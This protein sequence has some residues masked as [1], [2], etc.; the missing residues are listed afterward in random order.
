MRLHHDS[1]STVQVDSAQTSAVGS[2]GSV[3]GAGS[4]SKAGVQRGEAA[5]S[6]DSIAISGPSSALNRLTGDRATRIEQLTAAVRAGSYQIG[7]S[8]LSSSIVN[9]AVS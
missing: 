7:S 3:A 4:G 8:A 6:Q 5:G 2:S 1:A 9:H